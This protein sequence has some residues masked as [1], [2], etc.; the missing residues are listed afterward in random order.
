[1]TVPVPPGP[2]GWC[3]VRGLVRG[4][5]AWR[6]ARGA[7]PPRRR[8]GRASGRAPAGPSSPTPEGK[9]TPYDWVDVPLVLL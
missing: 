4:R 3:R 9:S 8:R 2:F 1:V 6:L 5:L 7:G